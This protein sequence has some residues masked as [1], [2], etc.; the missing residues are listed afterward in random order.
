[1]SQSVSFVL[2]TINFI[3]RFKYNLKIR[4]SVKTSTKSYVR[5]FRHLTKYNINYGFLIF[6]TLLE[7]NTKLYV[8][9][10]FNG[11]LFL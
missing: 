11:M 3:V 5:I 6:Y 4:N 2:N 7:L 1:M 9:I 8:N 10:V